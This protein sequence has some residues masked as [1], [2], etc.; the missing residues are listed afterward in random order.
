MIRIFTLLTLFICSVLSTS[1]QAQF[2]GV[3]DIQLY[4]K[5]DA[6]ITDTSLIHMY[7][8]P[9]RILVKGA[10][11]ES[12]KSGNYEASGLLIR[13]DQRDFVLMMGKNQALQLS[14]SEIEGF[15][16]MISTIFG[17]EE[18]TPQEL[19]ESK[20]S[21]VVTGRV[22]NINGYPS[23]EI[24]ITDADG[25]GYATIWTTI[26]LDIDWGLLKEPWL[27][28]PDWLREATDRLTIEFQSKS[29]PVLMT[30][31][32]DEGTFTFYELIRAEKSAVAKATVELPSN[33]QLLGF[34]DWI[35]M[36]MMQ[37]Y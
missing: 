10:E 4:S 37:Q 18:P 36:Q 26:K 23:K 15:F 32:S 33:Y 2:N 7:V 8:T 17:I 13:Q 5:N 3:L 34:S 31:T 6:G 25:S 28:S 20:S 9:E 30:W 1:T 24:K 29:V 19:A 27:N 11:E 21:V 14:K 16:T 35:I 12:I 22:E